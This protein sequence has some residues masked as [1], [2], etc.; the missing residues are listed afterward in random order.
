M[1]KKRREKMGKI[2]SKYSDIYTIER[3]KSKQLK[4]NIRQQKHTQREAQRKLTPIEIDYKTKR[5]IEEI[6]RRLRVGETTSS[7]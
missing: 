3:E 6:D 5:S 7:R 4:V 1:Q 2:K